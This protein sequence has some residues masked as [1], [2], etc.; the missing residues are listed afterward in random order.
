MM[1]A[2]MTPRRPQSEEMLTLLER[3]KIQVLLDAGFGTADVAQCT[4]FSDDTVRRV[5]RESAVTHTDD[6]QQRRERRVGRPSV[7]AKFA[8]KVVDWLGEEPDL[9]TQELFR[10]A[11]EA[12]YEG[13]KT[14]FY[15]SSPECGPLALLR[16]FVLRACRGSFHSTTSGSSAACL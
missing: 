13:R 16:S 8:E 10:R 2:A 7:A 3:H 4:G 14:A 6:K 15:G 9:P 1:S 5:Q 12:G 11:T